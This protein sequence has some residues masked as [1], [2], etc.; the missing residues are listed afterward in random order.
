MSHHSSV[1]KTF[2]SPDPVEINASN[3][4]FTGNR[5]RLIILNHPS[6][7]IWVYRTRSSSQITNMTHAHRRGRVEGRHRA[8]RL[9]WLKHWKRSKCA[10]RIY[11]KCAMNRN[12]LL[13]LWLNQHANEKQKQKDDSRASRRKLRKLTANNAGWEKSIHLSKQDDAIRATLLLNRSV[14]L[15]A[16]Y[17]EKHGLQGICWCVRIHTSTSNPFQFQST[18]VKQARDLCLQM[19][20]TQSISTAGWQVLWEHSAMTS[21][22]RERHQ[23]QNIISIFWQI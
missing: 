14:P 17:T 15:S 2:H 10:E 12:P 21:L 22:R 8:T 1:C 11:K 16:P 6:E 18:V 3:S 5:A 13:R 4:F 20:S 23:P 7:T 9:L 19:S